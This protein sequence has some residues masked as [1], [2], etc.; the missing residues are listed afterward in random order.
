[1]HLTP[2]FTA[3][4]APYEYGFIRCQDARRTVSIITRNGAEFAIQ[5][6]TI[7]SRGGTRLTKTR[8]SPA[9]SIRTRAVTATRAV[10]RGQARNRRAADRRRT[11][12]YE[13]RKQPTTDV[14]TQTHACIYKS[15]AE[16]NTLSRDRLHEEACFKFRSPKYGSV[17]RWRCKQ[18]G[19]KN[20]R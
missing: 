9:A 10:R 11:I 2:V 13:S 15:F 18:R 8:S 20:H 14:V 4:R 1:M 7:N 19:W 3:R 16:R 17:C 12:G 5:A 6:Y